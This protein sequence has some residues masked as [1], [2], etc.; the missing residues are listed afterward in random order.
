MIHFFWLGHHF[1][2]L[3]AS[4]EI[5]CRNQKPVHFSCAKHDKAW[6]SY[7][8]PI[9]SPAWLTLVLNSLE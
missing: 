4:S 9:N 7:W 6:S 3:I 5:G 2:H 8:F 1:L